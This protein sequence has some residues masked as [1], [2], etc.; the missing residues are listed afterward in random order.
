MKGKGLSYEC[1]T[2]IFGMS[3]AQTLGRALGLDQ[4]REF[5]S[6]G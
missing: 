1:V 2:G 4:V 3:T 6:I 5:P